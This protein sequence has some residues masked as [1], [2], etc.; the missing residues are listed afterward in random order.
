MA[1]MLFVMSTAYADYGY[2]EVETPVTYEERTNI[3]TKFDDTSY[4]FT[5]LLADEYPLMEIN[6]LAAVIGGSVEGGNTL[7]KD[8]VKITY[9][10]DERLALYGDGHLMLERVPVERDGKLFVPVSSLMPTLCYHIEF[11]R[12][13]D[14]NTSDETP[15]IAITTGT[16]YPEITKTIYAKD[17]GAVGDGVHDDKQ[18]VVDAVNAA[19]MAGVPTRLEFEAGKTYRLGD[20]MDRGSMIYMRYAK[21]VEINGNGCTLLI[22]KPV[23][24]F[25]YLRECENVKIKG[26]DVCWEEHTSTQG[27]VTA[28]EKDSITVKLQ[29]GYPDLPSVEWLEETGATIS[30]GQLYYADED[31]PKVTTKDRI[32]I[33]RNYEKVGD[34]EYKIT[35]GSGYASISAVGDRIVIPTRSS[36]YDAGYLSAGLDGGSSAITVFLSKDV[37]FEDV[38]I[39]GSVHMGVSVG[40]CSGRVTFRNY[41]MQ[42]RDGN[43]ITSN[44][45]GIHWWRN[46][47]GIILE[48]STM[49]ANLDDHLNT[50]GEEAKV[51]G[52]SEDNKTF[53]VDYQC[54]F[55]KGDEIVFFDVENKKTIGTAFLKSWE[56]KNVNGGK[57]IITLDREVP[58][59][60]TTLEN[61][62]YP[63]RVYSLGATGAGS[64]VRN[65]NFI[66][67]RRHAYIIRSQNSIFEG[68]TVTDCCGSAVAAMNEVTK[69][70][71]EGF[72]PSSITIR[73]N[74]IDEKSGNTYGGDK[75]YP[76]ELNSFGSDMY[77]ESTLDG[78]LIEG[79]KIYTGNVGHA[80]LIQATKDLYMYDN[81]I[82][83]ADR[84]GS[85]TQAVAIRNS[86]IKAIEGLTLTTGNGSIG[87]AITI[88]GCSV[89][90]AN[91]KN[92]TKPLLMGKYNIK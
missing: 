39:S 42:T 73:N 21:N 62:T 22:E 82:V 41:K 87:N 60:T 92:V 17:F 50:K 57:Y 66:N 72:F 14:P 63:T 61:A 9:T 86:E 78:A 85:S 88:E 89:N 38:S 15:V 1:V 69:D 45:D 23:N 33:E 47:A 54:N 75:F 13:G 55:V 19:M 67:S 70:A 46:R 34:R 32:Q 29:D 64:V 79:N 52:K 48:N 76:I 74:V 58:G 12:F 30:F 2:S 6:N 27:T 83:Y 80:I 91:I 16:N 43:L 4:N 49:T 36:N 7:V 37:T 77:A 59:V 25:V 65:N 20:R 81:E 24:S 56:Y 31:R 26:I 5:I 44:S 40:L 10:K 84:I 53:E 18:A 11:Y 35:C 90:E 8:T 28:V 51:I 3:V 68:N 71:C